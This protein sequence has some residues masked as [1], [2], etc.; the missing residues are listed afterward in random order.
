M[1][2]LK[3]L[4]TEIEQSPGDGDM[5]LDEHCKREHAYGR[6]CWCNPLVVTAGMPLVMP[7]S[8]TIMRMDPIGANQMALHFEPEAS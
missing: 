2:D 3:D 1:D 5:T 6:D 8:G 7:E 4:F